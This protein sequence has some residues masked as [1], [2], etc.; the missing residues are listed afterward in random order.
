MLTFLA[1][2]IIEIFIIDISGV[3]QSLVHPLLKKLFDIKGQIKVPLFDCSLCVVFHTGWIYLLAT[4]QFT[5]IAFLF[6][7]MVSFLSSHICSLLLLISDSI[8]TL[9]LL[10]NKA[11][12]ELLNKANESKE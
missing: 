5:A 8:S 12:N 10:L 4:N 2:A 11:L 7:T 6:T 3:M 9:I 1:I